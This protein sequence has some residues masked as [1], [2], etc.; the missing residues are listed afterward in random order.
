MRG[1]VTYGLAV[2]N[3]GDGTASSPIIVWETLPYGFTF[4][5]GT[6]N[7]PGS[8]TVIS[9][10]VDPATDQE[11]VE[12]TYPGTLSP[13]GSL[14]LTIEVNVNPI[15][16][17]PPGP[18][19]VEVRH[20]EDVNLSNNQSCIETVL[21][22]TSG[23]KPDLAIEKFPDS[24]FHYGQ[25]ASYTFQVSNVGQGSAS[26]PITLVDDLPNGITFDSY[27]DPFSTDW[28]CSASGQQVTCTYTGPDIAPGGF[29][30]ALIINVT[31]AA[32][33]RFPGGSDAV[34][35][36]AAVKHPGDVN[37]VNDLSCVTTVITR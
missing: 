30:P 6:A 29:L 23:E 35:N 36:F 1:M 18:N 22:L 13:N 28:S 20:P 11:V 21:T 33:D 32:I 9:P 2:K 16:V 3:V 4:V 25:S 10:V 5:L 12:C 7:P 37:N 34:E 15:A 19:C 26:S 17:R 14:T 27:S 24:E 31:I 8:C